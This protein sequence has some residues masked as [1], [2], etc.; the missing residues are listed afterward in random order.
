MSK[1]N[2][3]SVEEASQNWQISERSTRNYC[4]QGR[5]EGALLEGK[6]WKIPTTAQKPDRKHRHS[7]AE[8]TLLAFLKREKDASLKGGIYH[9]IQID[10]TY[11]SN[12]IEGSKLTH[13]QTRYIFETKTLGVTDKAV[14][15]D[16]IVETVN[17]FRCIDL[18][19]E[20]AHTK[21][22]ESFIKQLHFILKSG[23]TDS[24]KSWFKVG[25]YKMLE[26]E[27]GGS[28]TT[29]P[30]EVSGAIKAL[31][32]EYNSKSK[33]TFDD[34]LD[35]HVRFESIHPFQ[36]GNGRVGRLIMFKECLKHNI[37]PFIITEELKMYYYDGLMMAIKSL[38]NEDVKAL[39]EAC[40]DASYRGIKNWKSERGFLRDTCLTG[41]DAMKATLDYFG[42]K[43]E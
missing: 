38:A 32:K 39:S 27:V 4:A 20:G 37:V 14:K 17:H 7:S 26:N 11:N 18:I 33:I 10:L 24:Q 12:H 31:L 16:D 28:E 2:Y 25:D 13:D 43:Y 41:Q 19:I 30:S 29:K 42:I 35:F 3:I 1:V 23:T 5:V 21:L 8:D 9:K 22:T 6:T 34:I 36:D 40:L 15:V